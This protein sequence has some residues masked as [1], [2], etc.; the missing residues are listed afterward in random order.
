MKYLLI[1]PNHDS[2]NLYHSL[3]IF[4]HQV[5]IEPIVYAPIYI[6]IFLFKNEI[7]KY[8]YKYIKT[9]NNVFHAED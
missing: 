1:K 4:L 8:I 2:L 5:E 6:Y 9:S 3:K 7:T